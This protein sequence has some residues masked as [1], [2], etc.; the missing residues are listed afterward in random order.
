[1]NV[2]CKCM[3]GPAGKVAGYLAFGSGMDY[4]YSVARVPYP[5]TVEV[6]GPNGLGTFAAGEESSPDAVLV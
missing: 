4:M 2:H 1:M 3:N 6:Y 5:L